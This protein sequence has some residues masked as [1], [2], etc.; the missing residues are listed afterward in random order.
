MYTV[1]KRLLAQHCSHTHCFLSFLLLIIA[2]TLGRPSTSLKKWN[3]MRKRNEMRISETLKCEEMKWEKE[4]L[5]PT[6]ISKVVGLTQQVS[7]H[8]SH[9]ATEIQVWSFGNS[10]RL[11][12]VFITQTQ[13]FEFWQMETTLKKLSKQLFFFFLCEAQVFW[14]MGDETELYNSV[15]PNPNALFKFLFF[16]LA[17]VWI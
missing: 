13:F 15:P 1:L 9:N 17:I 6:V 4:K 12:P 14:I 7:A 16:L 10:K 3:E 8:G 2:P 5:K 11:L